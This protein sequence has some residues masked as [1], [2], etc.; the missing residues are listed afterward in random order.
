VLD[1]SDGT[2]ASLVEMAARL[3]RQGAVF[4]GQ[5]LGP[6]LARALETRLGRLPEA[7]SE[8]V[9]LLDLVKA[10]DVRIDLA[11]AQVRT[12]L[13]WRAARPRPEPGEPLALL[14]DRL[15]IAVEEP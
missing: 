15:A 12:L 1:G 6:R 5:W 4:P 10:T 3:R 13:W 7:A 11:P 14:G 8:A 9:A 2:L